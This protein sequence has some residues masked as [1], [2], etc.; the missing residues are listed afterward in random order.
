M[1]ASFRYFRLRVMLWL[2]NLES[3]S[4][5]RASISSPDRLAVRII[6]II[7]LRIASLLPFMTRGFSL[8][9]SRFDASELFR[10]EQFNRLRQRL[11]SVPSSRNNVNRCLNRI[12]WIHSALILIKM[13]IWIYC[14]IPHRLS[15]PAA[16]VA[17]DSTT[18]ISIVFGFEVSE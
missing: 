18:I 2:N 15:A 7:I 6:M 8:S 14:G 5:S 4:C 12:N 10:C 13:D 11:R 3:V 16:L 9:P 17:C 1:T